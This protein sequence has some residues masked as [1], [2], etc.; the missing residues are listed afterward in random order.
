MI[1]LARMVEQRQQ[2][3]LGNE[4]VILHFLLARLNLKHFTLEE[5]IPDQVS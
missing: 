5:E 3:K 4:K 2:G 1:P